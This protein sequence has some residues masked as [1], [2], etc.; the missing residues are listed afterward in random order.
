MGDNSVQASHEASSSSGTKKHAKNYAYCGFW[1][2]RDSSASSATNI[3]LD[4]QETR[5]SEDST[6][7]NVSNPA[8]MATPGEMT[9]VGLL[10]NEF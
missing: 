5:S 9:Q 6:L 7:I 1:P 3:E 8:S 4:S 2:S 10:S